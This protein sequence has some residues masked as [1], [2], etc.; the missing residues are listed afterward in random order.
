MPVKF[1]HEMRTYFP[2]LK[3]ETMQMGLQL[4]RPKMLQTC[5]ISH[6]KAVHSDVFQVTLYLPKYVVGAKKVIKLQGETGSFSE[7]FCSL[8]RSL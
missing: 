8:S 4:I 6:L 1:L 2:S 3:F 7:R 5:L